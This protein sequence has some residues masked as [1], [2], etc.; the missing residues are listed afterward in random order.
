MM[1]AGIDAGSRAIKVVVIGTDGGGIVAQGQT[2]QGV[3]QGKLACEL[4]DSVLA[5]AGLQRSQVRRIV[6]TGYGRSAVPVA[7]TTI[8]EITCHAVGVRHLV[9]EVQT[10]IDIGGQDSK[11]VR[12]DGRGKVRD[13]AMNDRC[14][15]GTGRFLEIV[16]GRLGLSLNDLGA[17]AARSQN[18]AAISSM[19]VVFAETEIIGLLAG[20]RAREDI[21]AGV[22][23]A[24]AARIIAM[25]GRHVEAPIVFTGGVAR[26]SGME[27]ALQTALGR[28]VAV[29]PEPQMT[30]ALG[31]AL[32]ARQQDS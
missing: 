26:I 10:I 14:A 25:A 7:D 5:Q 20:G 17:M 21:V 16:A 15:A 27:T 9:P 32:L 29:S 30:G 2:D 24:I 6:A 28:P 11:L 22:Q 12:L 3:E 4:F 8:T 13:F 1:Y 19:C 23:T 18:P 31:A